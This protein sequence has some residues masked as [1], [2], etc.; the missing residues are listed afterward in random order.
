MHRLIAIAL[1]SLLMASATV[2]AKDKAPA[3]IA[4]GTRIGVLNLLD[5]ELMHYHSAKQTFNSFLKIQAVTWNVDEM[6]NAAVREQPA[7]AA[8]EL[9]P[10]APTDTLVRARESCF[11]NAHLV[12]A[13][14]LPRDCSA[15]LLELA[16]SANVT[17]LIVMA[18]GLNNADHNDGTR[19]E[20]SEMLRGWGFVTHERGGPKDRPTLFSEV[21]LLLIAVRPDG[22][23]VRARQWGGNY[24]Y[25]W[26]TYTAP[27]DP[28][29]FPP[30]QLEQLQPLFATILSR[31]AKDFMDQVHVE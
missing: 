7:V 19:V 15:G 18:P 9:T 26:Q 22:I 29:A 3:P 13:K 28:K 6:L 16:A 20:E 17:Y 2:T 8:L 30:D 10:L 12:K 21:E 11:V 1:S 25:Q 31:Q 23:S 5:A 27:A 24:N 4:K 14:G